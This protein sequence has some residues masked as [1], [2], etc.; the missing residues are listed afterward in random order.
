M[1]LPRGEIARV[2]AGRVVLR[3]SVSIDLQALITALAGLG[4][5]PEKTAVMAAQLNKRA[6]QLAERKQRSYEEA[7]SH[8]LELMRQGWVAKAQGSEPP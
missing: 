5:P 1:W 3:N 4:Y 8:L 7:L 2:T 6:R